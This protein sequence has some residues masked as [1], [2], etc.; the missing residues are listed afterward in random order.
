[1]P[2]P[3]GPA[4]R[5]TFATHGSLR[6][7]RAPMG[8]A[9]HGR[10]G[11]PSRRPAH[12]PVHPGPR[13]VQGRGEAGAASSG[14]GR[15]IAGRSCHRGCEPDFAISVAGGGDGELTG[16]VGSRGGASGSAPPF[17]AICGTSR[18][19]GCRRMH[20]T[21]GTSYALS[22]GHEAALSRVRG[23]RPGRAVR[24]DRAAGSGRDDIA[25]G[26]SL[27][28]AGGCAEPRLLGEL[29]GSRVALR[30]AGREQRRDS[31]GFA[32]MSRGCAPGRPSIR[33]TIRC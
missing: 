33:R 10:R 31:A 11:V 30:S 12:E 23:R 16:R 17:T 15:A 26:R 22:S 18:H 27:R 8:H 28:C 25:L 19:S 1:M 6:S 5:V 32:P 21:R 7:V 3:S 29:G 9:D 20:P 14:A 24:R 2:G 13:G 4:S